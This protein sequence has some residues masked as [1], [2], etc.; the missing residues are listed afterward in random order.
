VPQYAREFPP[1]AEFV[2]GV[3]ALVDRGVNLFFIYSAA[4]EGYYNHEGQLREFLAGVDFKNRVETKFF[5]DSD[6]TFTDLR[7][8]RALVET[9][10]AWLPVV[11]GRSSAAA[12]A[13]SLSPPPGAPGQS[14]A[15]GS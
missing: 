15:E 10:L 4:M 2:A 6:H 11:A 3:Q 9:I 14:R 5:V 8:Q 13:P 7:S 1:Q 12:P